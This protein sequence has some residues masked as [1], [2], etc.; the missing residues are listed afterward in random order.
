MPDD[1]AREEANE[2]SS[3]YRGRCNNDRDRLSCAAI[4]LG[5]TAE[6]DASV[7]ARP[8]LCRHGRG[9]A[10]AGQ[11]RVLAHS[12]RPEPQ[13][14]ENHRLADPPSERRSRR[15]LTVTTSSRRLVTHGSPG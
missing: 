2:G 7:P 10:Q 3:S 8:Y 1:R 11:Y 15:A 9:G 4:E 13:G 5:P 6:H 14:A 12:K